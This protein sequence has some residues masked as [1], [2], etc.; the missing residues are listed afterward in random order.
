MFTKVLC[1][2][3][4]VD[5]PVREE[6]Q[7]LSSDWVLTRE[8]GARANV[9]PHTRL[10]PGLALASEANCLLQQPAARPC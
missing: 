9:T 1:N 6:A 2:V 5:S 10:R 7:L 4:P 3:F 8:Q